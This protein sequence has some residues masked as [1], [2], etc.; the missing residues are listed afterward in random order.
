MELKIDE[1]FV[2]KIG[3]NCKIIIKE[4]EEN[5]TKNILNNKVN[6]NNCKNQI[7][8]KTK[9]K[10]ILEY[11][12]F[13]YSLSNNEKSANKISFYVFNIANTFLGIYFSDSSNLLKNYNK[14]EKAKTKYFYVDN[15]EGNSIKFDDILMESYM[16]KKTGISEDLYKKFEVMRQFNKKYED[17]FLEKISQN[18]NYKQSE[19]DNDIENLFIRKLIKNENV[20]LLKLSN[21]IVQIFFMDNSKLAMTTDGEEVLYHN[22]K[23]S[24]TVQDSLAN[25]LSSKNENLI[26]KIKYAKNLLINFVK[27]EKEA[28]NKDGNLI[29]SAFLKIKK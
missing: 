6:L 12:N 8:K 2:K 16:S 24:E 18:K 19:S 22:K 13:S 23:M 3:N 9:I 11:G 20:I 28:T 25:I 5:T 21:K 1:N 14:K 15:K 10:K 29:N 4:G 26:N 17:F 27:N 7:S